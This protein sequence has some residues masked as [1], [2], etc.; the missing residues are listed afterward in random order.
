MSVSYYPTVSY[1]KLDIKKAKVILQS[2]PAKSKNRNGYDE[3]SWQWNVK[4]SAS[5]MPI[6]RE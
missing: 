2:M 3:S 6:K 4:S 1:Y 5:L